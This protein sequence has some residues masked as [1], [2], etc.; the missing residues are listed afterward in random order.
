MFTVWSVILQGKDCFLGKKTY[1]QASIESQLIVFRDR[2]FLISFSRLVCDNTESHNLVV[3]CSYQQLNLALLDIQCDGLL[4][5][6]M[7]NLY[8]FPKAIIL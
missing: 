7:M 4:K 8:F 2:A 6:S 3:L 5:Q 1:G